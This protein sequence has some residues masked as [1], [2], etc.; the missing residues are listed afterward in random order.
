[1]V[2]LFHIYSKHTHTLIFRIGFHPSSKMRLSLC[3]LG[4]AER[5]RER[6]THRQMKD[7]FEFISEPF[8]TTKYGHRFMDEDEDSSGW[9]SK[10]LQRKL[11]EADPSHASIR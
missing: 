3:W 11:D 1:M 2:E 8:M 7:D 10:R 6:D 5:E 9:F 4:Q